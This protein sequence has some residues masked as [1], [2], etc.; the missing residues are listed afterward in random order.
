VGPQGHYQILFRLLLLCASLT[1]L[2]EMGA[3]SIILDLRDNTGG[4]AAATG[5]QW[6][7][8]PTRPPG[9]YRSRYHTGAPFCQL[10]F[11]APPLIYERGAWT[12]S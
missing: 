11:L 5:R 3:N 1:S 12:R 6:S 9:R 8:H 10:H 2:R 7:E 4:Y